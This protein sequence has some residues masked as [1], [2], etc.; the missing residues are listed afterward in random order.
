MVPISKRVERQSRIEEEKESTHSKKAGF[1]LPPLL[2]WPQKVSA[3]EVYT[4]LMGTIDFYAT[5][6]AAAGIALPKKCDG[7]NLLPF[8]V[9]DT[10]GDAHDYLFWHN[11]DP[12][13][14]P[15]RNIYA[16]RWKQWRLIKAEGE[17]TLYDLLQDPKEE[18][19]VADTHADVVKNMVTHYDDFVNSLPPLKPSANYKGGGKVPKGWGWEIG[20]GGVFPAVQ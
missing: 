20:T 10:K 13:D 18:Q 1:I 16:V 7:K 6:A 5:A 8:L 19:D 9:T 3:G 2:Q 11:A 12:T 4:G 14:A 17:W 15:R